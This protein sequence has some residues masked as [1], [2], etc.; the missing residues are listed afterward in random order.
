MILVDGHEFRLIDQ[1]SGLEGIDFGFGDGDEMAS[2]LIERVRDA[3]IR[4][5]IDVSLNPVLKGLNFNED[6]FFLDPGLVHLHLPI[7]G[8]PGWDISYDMAFGK[9]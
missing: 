4:Q 2:F 7:N 3:G 8:F 6:F 9:D 5:E 1:V